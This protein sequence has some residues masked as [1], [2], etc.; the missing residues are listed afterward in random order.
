M[1]GI[2]K[3]PSGVLNGFATRYTEVQLSSGDFL[4]WSSA[5][6]SGEPK[7]RI[8]GSE[9]LEVKP[10]HRRKQPG[11]FYLVLTDE[12]IAGKGTALKLSNGVLNGRRVI[13]CC[14]GDASK[15]LEWVNIWG[16]VLATMSTMSSGT[17]SKV[18]VSRSHQV[19]TGAMAWCGTSMWSGHHV[20]LTQDGMLS[21]WAFESYYR[22]HFKPTWSVDMTIA[23]LRNYGNAS[24]KD[25]AST[26]IADARAAADAA[27]TISAKALAVAKLVGEKFVIEQGPAT[28]ILAVANAEELETWKTSI[29]EARLSANFERIRLKEATESTANRLSSRR[30][31]GKTLSEGHTNPIVAARMRK[32]ALAAAAAAAEAEGTSSDEEGDEVLDRGSGGVEESEASAAALEGAACSGW[33]FKRGRLNKTRWR[34]LFCVLHTT[35]E[36]PML[37]YYD[38]TDCAT[39]VGSM[40]LVDLT[41]VGCEEPKETHIRSMLGAGLA[42][43]MLRLESTS[44]TLLATATDAKSKERW[45]E[46]LKGVDGAVV[47]E[48]GEDVADDDEGGG[49]KPRAESNADFDDDDEVEEKEPEVAWEEAK[50]A[51][52]M[53]G[54]LTKKNSRGNVWKK[55]FFVLVASQY[56][57]GDATLRTYAGDDAEAR[58]CNEFVLNGLRL[59][60][61]IN[62]PG[63]PEPSASARKSITPTKRGL[64]RKPSFLARRA[65]AAL[66]AVASVAGSIAAPKTR[67]S[68]FVIE[69]SMKTLHVHADTEVCKQAWLAK[70]APLSAVP[71]VMGGSAAERSAAAI[72]AEVGADEDGGY[73]FD[74]TVPLPPPVVKSKPPPPPGDPPGRNSKP[75]PPPGEPPAEA[76]VNRAETASTPATVDAQD[77]AE[78]SDF[79]C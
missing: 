18:E 44:K 57:V 12:S 66:A 17:P 77:D 62:A 70:L 65:S 34:K 10:R 64:S 36:P 19:Y 54:F 55:R 69:T 2:C 16:L 39:L 31:T 9:I 32:A 20:V 58:M 51:A 47:T 73:S 24:V 22:Q 67:A 14:P 50:E 28:Y 27:V 7:F 78:S 76:R 60:D 21:A 63:T 23:R 59:T 75:P 35:E 61:V 74:G 71:I 52:L 25:C 30:R 1:E 48:H 45:L 11:S 43:H 49:S 46:A 41:A 5:R 40:A 72:D 4:V 29:E 26:A 13:V 37:R 3:F 53:C 15:G 42:P 8:K 38:A 6:K 68:A 79:E 56:A 33:L